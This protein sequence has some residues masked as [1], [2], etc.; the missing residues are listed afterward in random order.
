MHKKFTLVIPKSCINFTTSKYIAK[1]FCIK[2]KMYNFKNTKKMKKLVF[3][4]VAI[5][6]LGF[7]GNAQDFSFNKFF[8]SS[9]FAQLSKTFAIQPTDIDKVNYASIDHESKNFKIYRVLVNGNGNKNFITF[10][11]DDNNQNYAVIYEKNDLNKKL[12]EHYD[13]YENLYATFS[14][15]KYKDGIWSSKIDKTFSP[16]M[17]NN[18]SVNKKACSITKVYQ[19]LKKACESD[20]FCDTLCDFNPDCKRMLITWAITFCLSR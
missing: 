8:E 3:G 10:F 14:L 17:S 2:K 1:K 11:S 4:L 18:N 7:N 20:D 19:Q 13:E 12:A 9:E 16:N 5:I 6:L 15:S